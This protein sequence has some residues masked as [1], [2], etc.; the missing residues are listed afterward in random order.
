MVLRSASTKLILNFTNTYKIFLLMQFTK[1][2]TK[3]LSVYF[4]KCMEEIFIGT[5]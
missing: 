3:I 4:K 2:I 5:A 1:N